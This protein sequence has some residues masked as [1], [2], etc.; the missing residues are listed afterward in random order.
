MKILISGTP[1]SG[2]TTL[3]KKVYEQFK[4]RINIS[5]VITEEE[6]VSGKRVGFKIKKLGSKDWVWL[7]NIWGPGARFGKYYIFLKNINKMIEWIEEVEKN[8]DLLIID[9]YGPMELMNPNFKRKIIDLIESDK[10][11]ILTAHRKRYRELLEREELILIW[12]TPLNRKEGFERIKE[13][14]KREFNL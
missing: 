1:G 13:I 10:N 7:A 6:R 12:L 14:I 8:S 4:D 2:K 11:I 3:C 9:E 5:G